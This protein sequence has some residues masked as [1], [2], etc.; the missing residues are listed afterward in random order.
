[1]TEAPDAWSPAEIA[2]RVEAAALPKAAASLPRLM[3]LSMLAGAFIAFGALFYTLVVADSTLGSGPTRLIG[4]AAFSLGLI[5]VIVGGAELFTGN[6]LMVIAAAD[7]RISLS[8]LLRNWGLVWTG[9][10]AGALVIAVLVTLSGVAADGPV[11]VKMAAIADGKLALGPAEA[12]F[13]GVLCN[14]LVCLAVWMSFGAR[15]VTDKVLVIV[16]PIAA[17]V[18]VGFEHS[19]ANMYVIPVAMMAGLTGFD[20]SGL[21]LN[22]LFVTAGNV[23]GGGLLVGIVYWA[24]Y[25]RHLPKS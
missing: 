7:R 16:P 4:G 11:A 23:L 25:L 3:M 2:A 20:V 17:F 6:M 5:L 9:N 13:R 10:F 18:G 22:L 24:I 19:V 8:A 1:M 21:A 12:F 14:V 15:S